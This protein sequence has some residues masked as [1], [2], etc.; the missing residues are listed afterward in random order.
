MDIINV[1]DNGI[2]TTT[3]NSIL[4][5]LITEFKAIYGEN[6]YIAEGTEDY[7]MLL[8][9]A[10]ALSDMGQTAVSVSNG[11]NLTTATGFQLDNLATIFYNNVNRS[12]ATYSTVSVTITGTANTTIRNGQIKDE[13]GGI[14]N[15]PTP[16]TIP[17]SGSITVTA[18]HNE[19]GAYY[20]TA[21]QISGFNSIV[22]PVAGWTNVTNTSASTVGQEVE[23]D[24]QFRYRL[25]IASQANSKSVAGSLVSNLLSLDN[26]YNARLW[27]NDTS[28]TLDYSLVSLTGISAHSICVAVYGEQDDDTIAE[29]IYNY[30]GTGVGTYAP[31]DGTGSTSVTI[32]NDLEVSQTI[33][34]VKA[35][36][37]EIPITINLLN[38]STTSTTLD[39]VTQEAIQDA[40]IEYMQ[41]QNIGA[42]LYASALYTTISTAITNSIG[43]NVYNI[44]SVYFNTSDTTLQNTYYQK[45]TTQASDITINLT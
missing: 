41:D 32:T 39:T 19:A 29:T 20:I 36:A 40:L 22:T 4:Q 23:S 13:L 16:I 33:N 43:A 11:L 2:Q 28:D 12:S 44:Q 8:T 1:T 25:A 37:N 6:A 24:A 38:I 21:G 14:W 31:S 27:E 7:N 34:F 3:R 45:P 5:E 10:D 17:A 9:L 42:T 18:T 35:V 26:V 30:K 15:L